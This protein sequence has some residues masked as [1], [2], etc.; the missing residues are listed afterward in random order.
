M[1]MIPVRLRSTVQIR[2]IDETNL[3]F[4]WLPRE[5]Y[6]TAAT[7]LGRLLAENGHGLVYG[8]GRIGLMGV[9]ADAVIAG[10]G[11]AIGVIPRL[12]MREEI[13]HPGLSEL[14][15]VATMHERKAMMAELSDGFITLPG[16]YGTLEEFF[17]IVT[18]AQLGLHRKPCGLLNVD[19][20]YDPL[21]R[22]I[23]HAVAEGFIRAEQRPLV[24]DDS[25][26]QALLQRMSTYAAPDSVQLLHPDEV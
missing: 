20:Y 1:A 7:N 19:G 11:E 18:W 6:R 24:I 10:H 9:V 21:L 12:L 4:L 2:W 23:D 22:L 25:S 16:G 14:R 13:A 8:G 15:I 26:A 3:R 17:E 5:T